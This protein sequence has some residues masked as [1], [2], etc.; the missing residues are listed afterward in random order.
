MEILFI[1]ALL[2]FLGYGIFWAF[3][4]YEIGKHSDQDFQAIGQS[5]ALWF[6]VVLVLQFFGTITYFFWVRPKLKARMA[7]PR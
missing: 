4:L 5:R 1:L 2:V 3:M 6:V 7:L